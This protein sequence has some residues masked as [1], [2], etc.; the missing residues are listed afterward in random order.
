MRIEAIGT[1]KN[2]NVEEIRI[3]KTLIIIVLAYLIC[4][5]PPAIVNLIEMVSPSYKIPCWADIIT[6]NLVFANHANNPLIYG[7]FNRQYRRAFKE[8]LMGLIPGMH[9]S[10][11]MDSTIQGGYSLNSTVVRNR[12]TEKTT[13]C[14]ENEPESCYPPNALPKVSS[15]K[16]Q[17]A[18]VI[19]PQNGQK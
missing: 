14:V 6:V 19:T 8:L 5:V 10:T 15:P 9:Y 16:P 4:F 7:I 2:V 13:E 17:N 1:S 18:F 11:S 12:R 3:T